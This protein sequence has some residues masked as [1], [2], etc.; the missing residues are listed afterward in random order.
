LIDYKGILIISFTAV[1]NGVKVDMKSDS[2]VRYFTFQNKKYRYDECMPIESN[3]YMESFV[4][5]KVLMLNNK[6]ND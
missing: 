3:I 2:G 4:K 1:I 5:E 6:D